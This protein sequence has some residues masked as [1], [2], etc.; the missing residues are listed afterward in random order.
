MT[1]KACTAACKKPGAAVPR[2]LLWG[3]GLTWIMLEM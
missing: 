1:G 2:V 3:P